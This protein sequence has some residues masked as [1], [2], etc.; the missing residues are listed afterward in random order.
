MT[1][2]RSGQ[3]SREF[4]L[5]L[6]EIYGEHDVAQCHERVAAALAA[7]KHAFPDAAAANAAL[8]SAP[9]RTELGGNH[10]DHNYGR[11][12]A[13]S[14]QLDGIAW[15]EATSKA[16]IEIVSEGY[17]ERITVE[18]E[19][20]AQA[21]VP[22]EEERGRPAAL[23]RGVAAGIRRAG[24]VVG[25]IRAY[26]TS[27]V[28]PG[29]GL[30]SSAS[31]ELLISSV[32]DL[33]HNGGKLGAVERAKI[34]QYAENDFFGKPCGLMDQ[35]ACAIGGVIAIDFAGR[36]DASW[37][38]VKRVNSDFA[39]AGYTLCVVDSGGSHA[40]LTPDYAAVPEEMKAVAAALGGETLSETNRQKLLSG[41]PALRTRVG[42]RAILRALHFFEENERVLRQFEQLRRGDIS[43][44]LA[45][46]RGSG[47]SSWRLLQNYYPSGAPAEQ[48]IALAAAL[49]DHFLSEEAGQL[50]GAVRVHGGGF[51]GTVQAYIPSDRFEEYCERMSGWFGADA[52]TRLEIRNS[53]VVRVA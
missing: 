48:G 44:Y 45:E 46:V 40:D 5:R 22:Q 21:L 14:I 8:F 38:T 39:A 50:E 1:D 7:Y 37:P 19:P 3:E 25:G 35:L 28:L 53:G 18:L 23:V 12:L 43:S 29:S 42:D 10:T 20:G 11:V 24:G 4:E 51:A 6:A 31:F 41:L 32:I 34:A 17:P 9:G 47:S 27:D 36:N 13:A 52:V 15:A 2:P 30:S 26:V 16:R 33:L 49:T